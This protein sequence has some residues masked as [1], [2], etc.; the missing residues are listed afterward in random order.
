MP[1]TLNGTYWTAEEAA[2]RVGRTHSILCRWIRRTGMEL[3]KVGATYLFSEDD[4]AK[5]ESLASHMEN[6]RSCL[7]VKDAAR[8]LKVPPSRLEDEVNAGLI[9]CETD[10][11]GKKRLTQEVVDLMLSSGFMNKKKTKWEEVRK[12]F[13]NWGE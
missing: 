11:L 13:E 5:L 10:F 6:Y 3:T 4:M 1:I 2:M 9:P 8:I 12:L 7:T